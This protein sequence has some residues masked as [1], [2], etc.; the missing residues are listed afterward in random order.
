[1]AGVDSLGGKNPEEE[2]IREKLDT[3]QYIMDSAYILFDGKY[4]M[5]EIETMPYRDLLSKIEKEQKLNQELEETRMR[6]ARESEHQ[7]GLMEVAR[8]VNM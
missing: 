1:M 2:K 8:Q 4:S 6:R 3:Y 7:N 5:K